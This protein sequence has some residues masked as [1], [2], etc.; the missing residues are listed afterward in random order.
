MAGIYVYPV[1]LELRS[2]LAGQQ[3]KVETYFRVRRRSGGG[4]CGELTAVAEKLYCIKFSS[5]EGTVPNK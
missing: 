3:K 4:D 1:F 5:Q 2:P